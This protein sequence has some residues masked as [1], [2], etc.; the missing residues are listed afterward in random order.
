MRV[1]SSILAS[2]WAGALCTICLVVAPT[3]F[4][5]LPDRHLAGE[6]AARFFFIGMLIGLAIAL[7]LAI[8]AIAGWLRVP[9][10]W[11]LAL[12]AT[13]ASLPLASEVILGPLMQSARATGDMGRF[14]LL[15]GVSALLFFTA[16]AGAI[17][18][19]AMVSRRAE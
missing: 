13:T 12:I 2:L 14:G 1:I 9:K 16:C 5:L 17:A 18:V 8:L 6:L 15:H 4:A 11:G 3:L 7:T 10:R 19:V